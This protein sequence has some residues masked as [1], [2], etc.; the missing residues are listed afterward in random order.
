MLE[1]VCNIC[2]SVVCQCHRLIPLRIPKT[3]FFV[4]RKSSMIPPENDWKLLWR[5]SCVSGS[6]FMLPKTFQFVGYNNYYS[7]NYYYKQ[8]SENQLRN[9]IYEFIK[10]LSYYI[11]Y[12]NL[13]IAMRIMMMLFIVILSEQFWISIFQAIVSDVVIRNDATFLIEYI[14]QFF[15][16]LC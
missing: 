5:F 6:Y 16:Q 1:L 9:S 8:F 14:C 11:Q 15:V 7:Y 3:L 4:Y 2:L 12:S 13:H 10:F